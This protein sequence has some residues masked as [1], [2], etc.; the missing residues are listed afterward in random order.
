VIATKFGFNL[1]PNFDPR[2]MQGSPG[3]DSRPERI[4]QAAEGSLKRLKVDS[5]DLLY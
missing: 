5:I 3:L 2:G 4:K 1:D